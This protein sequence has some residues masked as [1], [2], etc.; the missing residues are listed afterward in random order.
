MIKFSTRGIEFSCSLPALSG[1]LL[2]FGLLCSLGFWQL[3]RGEQKR[4]L[5]AQQQDAASAEA[6]D[7]T[8]QTG[9]DKDVLRYRPVSVNGHYDTKHQILID[10]QMLNGKPGY[11]VLT[12]FLPD[13]GQPGVLVNRGWVALGVSREVLP[14]ISIGVAAQQVRG[15]INRFLEPGLKLKGA[16]IPG[17][18][19]PVR[20]QIVDS[21]L[22]A[23]KLGYALADYQI[24]LDPAQ[25]EGYQRQWK[26]AVAIPPEKHRAY[27][28]QWFGLALTLTALFIWISSRKIHRG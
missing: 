7:L 25:P 5:L 27:A 26:I 22:L 28:V 13:G 24:E 6:L 2:L 9:I 17:E 10:N 23:D 16:E 1:Y 12:P 20:V 14:D 19:W 3:G 18:T 8:R 21:K 11:L 4:I 15:R